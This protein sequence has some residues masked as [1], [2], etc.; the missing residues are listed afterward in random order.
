MIFS[1]LVLKQLEQETVDLSHLIVKNIMNVFVISSGVVL[2]VIVITQA[3]INI[4]NVV[5]ICVTIII[6]TDIICFF[7]ISLRAKLVKVIRIRW[8][9]W[10]LRI[11]N[12]IIYSF[13]PNVE[14]IRY[15]TGSYTCWVSY[16]KLPDLCLKFD[17]MKSH[18]RA[19]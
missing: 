10:S 17:T 19:C 4:I 9:V 2:I 12:R 7:V 6:T 1:A 11:F 15:C 16:Y 13:I 8:M 18:D 3:I 5:I 14:K